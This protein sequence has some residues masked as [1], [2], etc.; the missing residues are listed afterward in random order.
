MKDKPPPPPS[1]DENILDGPPPTTWYDFKHPK[2][3]QLPRH[4]EKIEW[5]EY[6]GHGA[7]GIVHKAKIGNDHEVAVKIVCIL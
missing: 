6:L 2:R 4:K 3:R 1:L 7:Q 5:L